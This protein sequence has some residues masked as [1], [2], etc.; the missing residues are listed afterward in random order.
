MEK[1]ADYSK[2]FLVLLNCPSAQLDMTRLGNV[3]VGESSTLE[4]KAKC[5][6]KDI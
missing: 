5:T 2:S 1:E 3:A 4:E 6:Y